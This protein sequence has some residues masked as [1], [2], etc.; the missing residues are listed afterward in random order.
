MTNKQRKLVGVVYVGFVFIFFYIV[1]LIMIETTVPA[2]ENIEAT[3]VAC[4]LMNGREELDPSMCIAQLEAENSR[5]A[6]R[7]DVSEYT[8]AKLADAIRFIYEMQREAR[9]KKATD[10]RID[11]TTKDASVDQ[12]LTFLAIEN[13]GISFVVAQCISSQLVNIQLKD[14]PWESALREVLRVV[15]L[16]FTKNH[17]GTVYRMIPLTAESPP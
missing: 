15:G 16:R 9:N 2:N 3:T 6:E 8:T 11:L 14:V 17:D 1:P 4:H 10:I 13:P 12:V 5:L 7:W